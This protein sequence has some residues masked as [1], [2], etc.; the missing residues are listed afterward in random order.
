MK[1]IWHMVPEISGATDRIFCH[2]GPFFALLPPW[3]PRKSKFWK[4]EK[5]TWRYHH[6]THVHP[7]WQSWC[8]V[9]D[10]WSATDRI[11]CHFGSI[12][13][14]L[15][16]YGPRKSKFWKHENNAWRYYHFTHAYHKWLS[17]EVWFLRFG[18][19]LRHMKNKGVL[20]S[21]TSSRNSEAI[22]VWSRTPPT[23]CAC[24]GVQWLSLL[25]HH[26]FF[27]FTMIWTNYNY[28]EIKADLRRI[29]ER[30]PPRKIR[31][32]LAKMFFTFVSRFHKV[33]GDLLR[34]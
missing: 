6:F 3:R 12:F 7:K 27:S 2:F 26:S 31:A 23:K 30:V 5:N 10:I 32:R 34:L 20:Q 18:I 33:R 11:F 21:H 16:P 4:I 29:L 14:L 9:P 19:R 24:G 8:M 22:D 13:V 25:E 15:P 1:V 28:I 17:Y